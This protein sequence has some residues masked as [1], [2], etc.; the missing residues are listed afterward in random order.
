MSIV[1]I[2]AYS[3][4]LMYEFKKRGEIILEIFINFTAFH[5]E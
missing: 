3:N 1:P 5:Y 4:R 2:K